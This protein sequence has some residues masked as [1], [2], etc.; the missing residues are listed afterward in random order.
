[1]FVKVDQAKDSCYKI[2]IS[3]LLQQV[4]DEW[5]AS[6]GR[7]IRGNMRFAEHPTF[8]LTAWLRKILRNELLHSQ[9][10]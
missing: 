10:L 4:Q 3:N 5:Q 9:R 6:I 7:H 8:S 2:V 1:M